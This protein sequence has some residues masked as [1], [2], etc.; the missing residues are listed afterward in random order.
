MD[1][2][3][4][5]TAS[6]RIERPIADVRAQYGDMDHHIRNNV[7]AGIKLEWMESRSNERKIK[8]T[9]SILGIP[10]HDV[11]F[12]EDAPDG[13]LVIRNVEGT[14]AGMS[15]LHTFV[16][17]GDGATRVELLADAPATLGRK[18][19]GPLFV[20]GARQVLKKA[21]REDKADLEGPRF[22][23]G[24][25]A[26]DVERALASLEKLRTASSEVKRAVLEAAC[27][28]SAADGETD[29]AERDALGRVAKI[30]DA[31]DDVAWV[32]EKHA[33]YARMKGAV[34]IAS[35][36]ERIGAALREA[37]IARAGIVAAAV[38]GLVSQGM[39]LG[40]LALL[41][42]MAL[43]AGLADDDIGPI[44]DEVDRALEVT[45]H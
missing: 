34:E 44:V 35:Q 2:R 14:N 27:V 22:R 4:R 21:L 33:A 10:Q 7:H 15:V 8:T 11:A 26:G 38:V 25:A 43:A 16:D 36:S 17:L 19:L 5:V 28:V 20:A 30:L 39:S 12:L 41:R 1:E 18:L 23:R 29:P 13:T 6:I 40:E 3:I 24:V 37:G 45:A 9:F 31:A 42:R 32:E